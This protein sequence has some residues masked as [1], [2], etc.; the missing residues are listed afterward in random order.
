MAFA[1]RRTALHWG[2]DED[3]VDV[4]VTAFL[5]AGA[6]RVMAELRPLEEVQSG[7]GPVVNG[8]VVGIR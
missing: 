3:A 8:P 6:T 4:A 2:Q 5:L 7:R 1:V